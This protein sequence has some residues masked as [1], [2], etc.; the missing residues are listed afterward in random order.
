MA[1]AT[2]VAELRLFGVFRYMDLAR[3]GFVFLIGGNPVGWDAVEGLFS[4]SV[5]PKGR[6]SSDQLKGT[7]AGSSRGVGGGALD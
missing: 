4:D 6:N 7:G 1:R 5:L 2:G 3:A